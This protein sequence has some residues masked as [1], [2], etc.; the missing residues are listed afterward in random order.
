[1]ADAPTAPPF[2]LVWCENGGPPTVKHPDEA[3]AIREAER[4]AK[5][6]PGLRFFV[7]ATI[8]AATHQHTVF[9]RFDLTD[10]GIPF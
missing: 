1:M 3:S 2:W 7:L 8:C 10:D 9:E 6:S 5:R 4:L